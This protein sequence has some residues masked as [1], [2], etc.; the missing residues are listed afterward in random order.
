MKLQAVV[1]QAD[2]LGQACLCAS[3][4]K[5]V[6]EMSEESAARL[7]LLNEGDGFFEMRVT[8]MG[9]ATESVE[10]EDVEVLKKRETLRGDVAHIREV[11]GGAEAQASDLL[12]AMHDRD[13][14]KTGAEEVDPGARG[15]IEPVDLNASGGRVAIFCAEGVVEDALDGGGSFVIGIDGQIMLVVEAER[16]EI[17]ESHDVIGVTVGV[18]DCVDTADVFAQGLSVKVR[19]GVDQDGVGVVLKAYR[20]PGAAIARVGRGAD[21]AVTAEGRNAHGG[22]TA[23]ECESRL[24]ALADDTRAAGPSGLG[25]GGTSERLGDFEEG[26]ADLKE[27]AVEKARLVRGQVALGFVGEYAEHV[28]ALPGPEEIDLGLLTLLSGTAELH[29]GRHVDGLDE[30]F[31]AH[32]GRVLHAGVGCADG[33]IETVGGLLVG[34]AGLL[35]LLR[36]G[37]GR[38]VVILQLLFGWGLR[39]RR[40]GGNWG[41][42]RGCRSLVPALFFR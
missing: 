2:V 1:G 23:Q 21:D 19:A 38:E 36:S 5:I 26:H 30:L 9:L 20:G 42:G 27:C 33:G 7:E 10:D 41:G 37:W 4:I 22:A 25:G 28:D 14:T 8:G 12:M 29:D 6:A 40:R 11:G 17:I 18:D 31:E 15:R 16:P 32:D 35:G 34:E 24:H 39:L 3:V 13:A